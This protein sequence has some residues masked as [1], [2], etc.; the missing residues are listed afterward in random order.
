M[1]FP[2]TDNPMKDTLQNELS[3]E[4]QKFT[5]IKNIHQMIP[6]CQT[7]FVI[8]KVKPKSTKDILG[9]SG[10]IVKLEQKLLLQEI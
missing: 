8:S 5:Q 6:E 9:I 1:E 4:I 10:R 7:N 2:V 3:S